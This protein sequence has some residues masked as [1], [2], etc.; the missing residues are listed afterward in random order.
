[1]YAFT[2]RLEIIVGNPFVFVPVEI[3]AAIFDQAGNGSVDVCFGR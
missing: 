3:L 2:A 1:M